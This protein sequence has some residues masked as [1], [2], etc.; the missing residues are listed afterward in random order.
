M[1]LTHLDEKMIRNVLHEYS[2]TFF[3][4]SFLLVFN[5]IIIILVVFDIFV[6]IFNA[7]VVVRCDA[8]VDEFIDVVEGRRAY[9]KCLYVSNFIIE[10][11]IILSKLFY[12]F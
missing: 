11:L 1:P 4:K 5:I 8:T 10:Y 12:H 9:V 3:K 6:E 7:E 2:I